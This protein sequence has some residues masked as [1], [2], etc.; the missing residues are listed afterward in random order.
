MID[1][2][3][4]IQNKILE[5]DFNFQQN[6]C[7]KASEVDQDVRM[8]DEPNQIQGNDWV[9]HRLAPMTTTHIVR[10]CYEEW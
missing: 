3:F 1:F 9:R 7:L 4:K 2:V 10:Y 6:F 8:R 5:L